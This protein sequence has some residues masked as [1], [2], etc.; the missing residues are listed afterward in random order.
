MK[1]TRNPNAVELAKLARSINR[2]EEVL[3][4]HEAKS[5]KGVAD[6]LS[7]ALLQGAELNA[8]R[9]RCKHGDW[10]DWLKAN[11]PKVH[12]LKANRYMHMAANLS[13]VR[14]LTQAESLRQALQ[15]VGVP[16]EGSA[17]SGPTQ[18]SLPYVEGLSKFSK[19]GSF[20]IRNPIT[21]WPTEGV[22]QLREDLEPVAKELWPEKF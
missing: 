2:R 1:L 9:A 21:T 14:N 19:F 3:L 18:H 8:A 22:E 4:E 11:C 7:D 5:L 16:V 20:L 12:Y 10:L 13:R 6:W 15:L 17:S